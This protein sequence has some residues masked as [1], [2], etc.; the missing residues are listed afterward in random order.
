[1]DQIIKAGKSKHPLGADWPESCD[2][3]W[4]EDMVKALYHGQI[5]HPHRGDAAWAAAMELFLETEES[6]EVT[7]YKLC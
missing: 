2:F 5:Q 3:L 1:M 4:A 6:K 7:Y